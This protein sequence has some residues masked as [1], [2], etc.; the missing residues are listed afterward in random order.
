MADPRTSGTIAIKEQLHRHLDAIKC[1]GSFAAFGPVDFHGIDPMIK[2]DGVG[3]VNIPLT[4]EKAHEI[5]EAEAC[6]QAPFGKGEETIVDT[7]VR[8]T[9]E[10]NPDQFQINSPDW[11]LVLW[12]ATR[13]A[14]AALGIPQESQSNVKAHLYKMLLYQKGAIFKP[15]QE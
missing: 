10:L 5:I 12:E 8:N 1:G 15:H 14:A 3:H 2:I 9:W 6:H 11:Q 13:R 7:S 4:E